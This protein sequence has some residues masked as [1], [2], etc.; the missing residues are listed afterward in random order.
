MTTISATSILASQHTDTD[1]NTPHRVD[2]LLLRYPR[3]IHSK[4]MTHRVFSRNSASSRAIPVSKLIDDILADPFVPLVWGKNQRGMQSNEEC[5]NPILGNYNGL[6]EG[7][8]REHAWLLARDDAIL[9]AKRFTVAGYHKQIVNRLLEPWM[10]I[11]VVVTSTEWDNFFALRDHPDAEPHIAILAR[12]IKVAMASAQ[13]QPLKP[14]QWHLPFVAYDDF[15][16]TEHDHADN[17]DKAI[18]LSVARCASTSYKT[19][20]GF[21]MSLDRA[22]ELHDKLI[23]STPIH[24]SPLEHQ[25]YADTLIPGKIGPY[26]EYRVAHWKQPYL[27]GNF[28]GFCQYRR[29]IESRDGSKSQNEK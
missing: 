2:T 21:D 22:I 25:C 6:A 29:I 27:H 8:D 24:A 20:E 15:F 28:N 10:H 5:T 16:R 18:K 13:V 19:V 1:T 14:E 23:S 9:W 3:C 4:F 17:I 7:I 12:A 11:T 26:G